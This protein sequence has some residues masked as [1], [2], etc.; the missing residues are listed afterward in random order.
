MSII[1]GAEFIGALKRCFHKIA[2][3]SGEI[4][5]SSP[6]PVVANNLP[7]PYAIPPAE[8]SDSASNEGVKLTFHS[9][10]PIFDILKTTDP[11]FMTKILLFDTTGSDVNRNFELF[12]LPIPTF[13]TNFGSSDKLG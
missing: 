2:P 8:V 4:A 1:V 12:P 7:A 5:K 9:I 3:S 6:N 10:K 11:E 13:Q